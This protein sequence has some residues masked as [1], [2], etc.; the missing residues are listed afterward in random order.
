MKPTYASVLDNW[1]AE[2]DGLTVRDGHLNWITAIPK[3]CDR[4][5]NYT[6]PTGNEKL[7]GSTADGIYDF[8][9][10][11]VCP[12]TSIAL[13]NG[14]TFSTLIATG[15]GNY[16]QV[17]NGTDTL[18]QFDGTTWSSVATFSGGAVATSIFSYIEVYRQ[19]LFFIEKA[20]LNIGYLAPNSIA[21]TYTQYPL[22]ALFRKGGYLVALA[23]WTLDGGT[24]PEDNLCILSSK[25][26]I[27]VYVG[28]DPATWSLRGVYQSGLPLGD[29]PLYKYGGDVLVLTETGIIP[30]SSL[31]QSS[32]IDRTATVSTLIRPYLVSSAQQFGAGQGWQII[33]DPL[34]PSLIVNVPNSNLNLRQQAVMQAQTASWST[35]SGQNAIHFCRFGEDMY[36][37][38]SDGS[39]NAWTVQHITGNSD[40]GTNITATMLQAFS[41]LG[42]SLNKKVELVKAYFEATGQFLYNMGIASDFQAV[43]EYTQLNQ[44]Q[45]LSASLWGSAI[46]GTATWGAG[47]SVLDDWEQVPD[48]YSQWKALYLQTVSR[49]GSVRYLGCDMLHKRSQSSF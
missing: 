38:A 19:R 36:Y 16:M 40:N 1:F 35:F 29:I 44:T 18:K 17:V 14:K 15:A 47:A 37:S 46:W 9:S 32:S 3:Q 23:T 26:E 27:A 31:V 2:P 24:G 43:T 21:G 30:M 22:G 7:F 41:Q 12:A 4:L 33:S 6:P 48:E 42:Y 8:S 34:K 49:V 45:G 28:N 20:S 10:A 39:V 11:G 13:T 25:G 5:L